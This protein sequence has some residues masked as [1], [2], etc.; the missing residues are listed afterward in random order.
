MRFLFILLLFPA[1]S[2]GQN[3]TVFQLWNEVGVSYKM[4]KKQSLGLDFS[5]RSD[6][7]GIQTFF[8]QFSYRFKMNKH[9]RPSLDYRFV[10]DRNREGNFE[11]RHRL[12]A[13]L[14][15]SYDID[16]L[17]LDFRLRYQYAR[18]RFVDDIEPE[19]G[20]ALRYKTSFA[21]DIKNSDLQPKVS[22]EFFTG[23]MEGQIGYH[24][25]RIRWNFGLSYE[26]K[27]GHSMQIAYLYDQRINSPGSLNRAILN[28]SY[29]YSIRKVKSSKNQIPRKAPGRYL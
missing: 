11:L 17:E 21:Y 20:A 28:F 13:N 27:G 15:F 25:N 22:M 1:L 8:P 26:L 18:T 9:L 29:G 5:S 24:L 14:Q 6:A 16:Q 7:N 3:N 4:D 2:W 23:P 10:S 19:F 12:N